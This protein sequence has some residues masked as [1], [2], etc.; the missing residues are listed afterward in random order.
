MKLPSNDKYEAQDMWDNLKLLTDQYIICI[1][2]CMIQMF[3]QRC[4]ICEDATR[5][6]AIVLLTSL[7]TNIHCFTFLDVDS[8]WS[9]FTFTMWKKSSIN[10]R[11][12]YVC[13]MSICSL[14]T[15]HLQTH[16]SALQP[17]LFHL[18]RIMLTTQT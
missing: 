8:P 6:D 14:D 1:S 11:I 9:P 7:T 5:I 17:S 4:Q 2:C 18:N 15:N 3:C 13:D 12:L 16:I 10:K